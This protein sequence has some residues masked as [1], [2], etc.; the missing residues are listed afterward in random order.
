MKN[1][2]KKFPFN[3]MCGADDRKRLDELA[4][5][6]S[7]ARAHLT[8]LAI[9]A[10]HAMLVRGHPTCADGRPCM[11]PQFH[12]PPPASDEDPEIHPVKSP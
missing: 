2:L 10:Y 8:R 4:A 6:T 3:V 7:W 5:K 12:A 9:T 11:C 1:S